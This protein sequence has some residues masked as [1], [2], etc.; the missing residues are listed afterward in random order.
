MKKYLYFNIIIIVIVLLNSCVI[1]QREYLINNTIPY[2]NFDKVLEFNREVEKVYLI[3]ENERIDLFSN[4]L[5]KYIIPFHIVEGLNSIE[6]EFVINNISHIK[7]INILP[8]DLHYIVYGAGN[9]DL[10]QIRNFLYEDISSIKNTIN[11]YKG[12]KNILIT[13]IADFYDNNEDAI[14]NIF[15]FNG[16]YSYSKNYPED[17]GFTS[18]LRTVNYDNMNNYINYFFNPTIQKNINSHLYLDFWSHSLAWVNESRINENF[19]VSG[20]GKDEATKEE[21]SIKQIETFLKNFENDY[22]KKIDV[23]GF[24]SCQMNYLE[25]IYQF[26]EYINYFVASVDEVPGVGWDYEFLKYYNGNIELLLNKQIEYYEKMYKSNRSWNYMTLSVIN[27]TNFKEKIDE[28]LFNSNLTKNDVQE[29]FYYFFSSVKNIDT[30]D[31][32]DNQLTP[33]IINSFVAR[34]NQKN[35]I[36]LAYDIPQNRINDY[37]ELE[38]YKKFHYWID[39]FWKPF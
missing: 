37:K 38:F 39:N 14:Y 2:G 34:S 32:F 29:D 19:H 25:I 30:K 23:L 35:G 10:T 13:I 27:T 22:N 24:N 1:F 4:N 31:I 12:R 26:S 7:E 33:Y 17:Y 20:F 18:P 8:P 28:I 21:L 16:V 36:G 11:K 15:N 3:L 6:I 5:K 9:N